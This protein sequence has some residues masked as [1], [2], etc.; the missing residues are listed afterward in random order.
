MVIRS[1]IRHESPT[2]NAKNAWSTRTAINKHGHAERIQR[3][4][5][6]EDKERHM[7][8]PAASKGF[9]DIVDVSTV[10][11]FAAQPIPRVVGIRAT[12]LGE[13]SR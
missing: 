6:C 9:A 12:D 13:C 10:I 7:H 1:F 2:T 3:L 11:D 5:P 4:V 8:V